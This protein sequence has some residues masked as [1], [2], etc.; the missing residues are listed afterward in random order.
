M[1]LLVDGQHE[2]T[3]FATDMLRPT[4]REAVG[5]L[6]QLG[7]EPMLLTGDTLASAEPLAAELGIGN[8]RAKLLPAGKVDAVRAL[9]HAGRRV[10][11][12]GDG[13]NDAAALAQ[14]DAGIAVASGTDL[15]REAGHVLLLHQDLHLVP[16]AVRLARRT[17]RVMR[18]NLGWALLYNVIGLPVAAG[19][20][21][22]RFGFALSPALA[23]AAMAL[24]SVSVLVN[25]LRLARRSK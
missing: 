22:P 7:L 1:Y 10:A 15:A 21:L 18:Q 17:R 12:V 3:F 16:L 20:L 13:L 9:Q 5:Q 2:A 6:R 14:A 23:S 4:A 8:V 24:S 25:S 11:M 19:V